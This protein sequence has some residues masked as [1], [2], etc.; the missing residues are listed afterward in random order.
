MCALILQRHGVPFV[1]LEKVPAEKLTADMGSGFELAPTAIRILRQLGLPFEASM[2]Q[3]GGFSVHRND[4]AHLRDFSVSSMPDYDQWTVQRSHL[5][6]LLKDALGSSADIRCGAGVS[7]YTE[8]DSGV[9]VQMTD[10]ASIEGRALLACEGWKSEVRSQ[11]HL[12]DP[13]HFCNTVVYWGMS[14]LTPEIRKRL[15]AETQSAPHGKAF[16]TFLG[17]STEPGSFNGSFTR[18]ED[19]MWFFS[20]RTMEEP[21]KSGDL[22]IRGG[23]RG[24]A[25]KAELAALMSRR[26]ELMKSLIACSPADKV[27]KV[28]LYDRQNLDLPFVSSGGRV[29]LLGDAAHPQTPFLGQGCNMALADAFATCTRLAKQDVR[30]ALRALD[31]PGRKAFAKNVVIEAR[32]AADFETSSSWLLNASMHLM[33]RWLPESMLLRFC[34]LGWD[35]GNQ[36]FVDL[37]LKECGLPL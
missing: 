14:K 18:D 25:V 12:D 36:A 32:S 26:C 27:T 4:G 33:T 23:T 17:T 6:M 8:T 1:V 28:G 15:V 11:M 34:Q 21:D 5:Q 35:E 30:T 22:Q 10:G 3:Y 24:E 37:A 13:V 7:A 16:V 19:F 29:A 31:A 20:M 9:A 2:T